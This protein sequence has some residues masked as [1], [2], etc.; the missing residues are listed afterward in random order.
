MLRSSIQVVSCS[1]KTPFEVYHHILC[2]NKSKSSTAKKPSRRITLTPLPS[3]PPP[4]PSL[5]PSPNSSG[6]NSGWKSNPAFTNHSPASE[7]T[8]PSLSEERRLLKEERSRRRQ[9][10]GSRTAPPLQRDSGGTHKPSPTTCG[11]TGR[12]KRSLSAQ[13]GQQVK[14]QSTA[15]HHGRNSEENGIDLKISSHS[16][17]E[18]NCGTEYYSKKSDLSNARMNPSCNALSGQRSISTLTSADATASRAPLTSTPMLSK[19]CGQSL[20]SH[21]SSSSVTHRDALDLLSNHYATLITGE[22]FL[23]GSEYKCIAQPKLLRGY[24]YI[25]CTRNFIVKDMRR[26]SY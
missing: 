18:L 6:A 14:D 20:L 15:R 9:K 19:G 13:K 3:Q 22:T 11:A 25:Q 10:H 24:S 16:I 7:A 2:R 21:V 12:D 8:P 1:T 4:P 17:F 5:F 23:L 26:W